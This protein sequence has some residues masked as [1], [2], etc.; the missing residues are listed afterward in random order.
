MKIVRL[1][2]QNLA[3]LAGEQ[4]IDFEAEPLQHAGL[5]AI[6]GATGAGK[7]TLLDAMCL[8]LFNKIPRLKT[9]E[10]KLKDVSGQDIQIDSTLNILRRG[11]AHA[12]SELEFI[13]Q[14]QKRYIARW[15][16]K[17]AR[18]HAEGKLQ[19][20]QRALLCVSDGT[21]LTDKTK[22]CDK[23]ILDLIGLSF[24]QFTRAVLLAQS[25]VG[26]FLKAKDNERADLL[27]YLTNSNIFSLVGKAA[28][29]KT[30]AVRLQR[31]KLNELIG[32][33]ELLSP[34]QVLELEQHLKDQQQQLQQLEQQRQIL[35][36][37]RQWHK[38]HHLLYTQIQGKQ[39]FYLVQLDANQKLAEQRQQLQQLEQFA[40]IRPVLIQQ[41]RCEQ[42]LQGLEHRLAQ[43]QQQFQL[44]NGQY[45]SAQ[46][47]Y[48]SARQALEQE[49]TRQQQLA[50]F[51][52]QARQLL[53]QRKLIESQY[54][55][56]RSRL[57]D[58]T[59]EQQQLAPQLQQAETQQQQLEQVQ[60]QFRQQLAQSQHLSAFD[61]EPQASLQQLKAYIAYAQELQQQLPERFTAHY[62][63][64]VQAKCMSLEHNLQ[65]LH[66][67]NANT[68]QLEQTVQQLYQQREQQ[69]ERG[70]QLEQLQQQ[71]QHWQQQ[72]Q[73][74][75]TLSQGIHQ[76][77]NEMQQ[78]QATA[79][80]QQLSH[81][82]CKRD[83]ELLQK[84]LQQ[85]RLLFS[86]Q[87]E[88]LRRA[89]QPNEPCAVCGSVQHP[90]REQQHLLEKTL[91]NVQEQQEQA[92]LQA[93][94]EAQRL[95]QATQQ[96][97]LKQDTSR[98]HLQQQQQRLTEQIQQRQQSLQDQAARLKITL[99]WEQAPEQLIP[100]V[101][102]AQQVQQ[103]HHEQLNLQIS[104]IQAVQKQLSSLTQQ[105]DQAR[106][107][108]ANA[109]QLQ[110]LARPIL[111]K[112]PPARQQDYYQ[113]SYL[114]AQALEQ[115]FQARL[116]LL[117][118]VQAQEQALAQLQQQLHPQRL[119]QQHLHEY[120]GQLEQELEQLK[121]QGL[122]NVIAVQQLTREASGTSYEQAQHWLE[123]LEQQRQQLE[124]QL[125]EQQQ[126]YEALQQDHQHQQAGLTE[127][128]ATHRHV[129]QD[130]DQAQ[131]QLTQW[132][133]THPDYH[134]DL[135][136]QLL[137]VTSQQEQRIRQQLQS[138]DQVLSEAKTALQTL[139]EQ[140]E[141]HL[142]S[143][144]AHEFEQLHTLLADLDLQ[145]NRVAEERDQLRM[146]L[147]IQQRNLKKQQQ[148]QS[149]IVEVQQEEY[150]WNRISELIGSADGS[151][152]KKIAQE[153]HLDILVEYA[154]QQLQ[155]LA[156]R[157]QLQRIEN[158]L[159]LAI[160]DH[161]MNGEVRPVLSLSGGETFLVS[162]ALALA[163]ANMAAGSMKIESLFIDEGFGT[164]D[165]ASLHVVM[166]ALDRLQGQGR[167][168][169]LISHVQEM[170]ERIPIQIQVKAIGS[171]AS[172]IQ[173]VG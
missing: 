147:E 135:L 2:L 51:I 169:T 161:H 21:L 53:D 159:G 132:L 111:D 116:S 12:Y 13:A 63:D 95:W 150:R 6:T 41:K 55:Q 171:G 101:Q 108:A 152:F 72:Y 92:Y 7:S 59:A 15:E 32:H 62:Y 80:E 73:E 74:Q 5:I 61:H 91:L 87:V 26:A 46:Q 35:E 115:A 82:H 28:F 126:H 14:N 77:E 68:D 162:L 136:V 165:P 79:A 167:K 146:K 133:D 19:A 105:L 43:H 102:Q 166:D 8:A 66:Q 124:Q 125:M 145:L 70:Y 38:S 45:Q 42:Q 129:K 20:V 83:R 131:T 172:R 119:Q 89:L 49:K 122:D 97:Y 23:Q 140:F 86:D 149:Q 36:N 22:E 170:H 75:Q 103:H 69:M 127:L 57:K 56:I 47:R 130:L 76:L 3:S 78:L 117:Q 144:P 34:E 33:V 37:E 153:H 98:S 90:Y 94:Q 155:P 16:L 18:G 142:S 141:Q 123:N 120:I 148:F 128:Q 60:Q 110:Q 99:P 71:L 151:R 114:D 164:L 81:E 112:L 109:Q 157:Y 134:T 29:E 64:T 85:Q 158:S 24:E 118:E 54:V 100:L 11:T 168:V 143:K 104:K 93:E 50:P 121:Q 163:I 67:Q 1:K 173:I 138:H 44:L 139:Q 40:A 65:L 84:Q 17:R 96:Q 156:S 107:Q 30:K 10:G 137:A 58:K 88:Q 48:Q 106:Q 4:E 27:E 154:N 39:E 25:E 113:H 9:H 160:I 31:E 52:D